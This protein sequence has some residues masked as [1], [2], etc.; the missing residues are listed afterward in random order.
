M[1]LDF[2]DEDF[3]EIF[4]DSEDFD[5]PFIIFCLSLFLIIFSSITFFSLYLLISTVS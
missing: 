1:S 2:E 4:D 5:D 3:C